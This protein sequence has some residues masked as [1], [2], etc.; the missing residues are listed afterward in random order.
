MSQLS[1][2]STYQFV[3]RCLEMRQKV[4]IA[5][6]QPDKITYDLNL[7]QQLFLRILERGIASPYI[8]SEIK[9]YLKVGNSDEALI[10]AVSRAAAA[11]RDREE[12]FAVRSRKNKGGV[13]T[14]S[15]VE[16]QSDNESSTSNKNLTKFFEKFD[17]RMSE[18][19]S[20]LKSLTVNTQR[21]G[22]VNMLHKRDLRC[23]K[24]KEKILS[25]CWHCFKRPCTFFSRQTGKLV[26]VTECGG[27][28]VM[29][30][31]VEP[32]IVVPHSVLGENSKSGIIQD[33]PHSCKYVNSSDVY[34]SCK[35]DDSNIVDVR[36]VN[37]VNKVKSTYV[38][39][40]NNSYNEKLFRRCCYVC[41][42]KESKHKG[43]SV[44]GGCQTVYYYTKS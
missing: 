8:L 32:P 31:C 20:Q 25:D 19:E 38:N 10:S 36:N 35:Y 40:H 2:E 30:R 15:A 34:D 3:I 23:K 14:I 9:P 43:F 7:V 26:E 22:L 29:E 18:I 27:Y 11:E 42:C 1:E 16:H 41:L 44:C 17:K 4:I 12:K 6:K 37:K 33:L 39:N 24:C 5:S 21:Q 13:F 28:P